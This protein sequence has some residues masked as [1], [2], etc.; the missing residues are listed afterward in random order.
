MLTC[1]I[2]FTETFMDFDN[3]SEGRPSEQRIPPWEMGWDCHAHRKG[4]SNSA[5]FFHVRQIPR[6]DAEDMW[7]DADGSDLSADWLDVS[8]DDPALNYNH[9]G[10]EYAYGDDDDDVSRMTRPTVVIVQV[11]Y[12]ERV[13]V[14]E[15]VD[16]QTGQKSEMPKADWDKV[17]K[18]TE[19]MPQHRVVSRNVWRQAF[20]GRDSILGESQPC[21]VASTFRPMTGHW[22][23]KD[24]RFYGLLRS[25]RDPQRFANKWL[26]NTLHILSVNSKGGVI[27]EK[28]AVDDMREFEES[29]AASDSVSV[30][31]RLDGIQPKPGPQMPAALMALTEFAISSIRDVS[32]V[33]MELMGMREAQQAGVLEYQRR[34]ASMTTLAFYFDSLR[35]YRKQQGDV[36][37]WFLQKWIAPTGR[38]VRIV[39]Q[40]QA[41]YVPLAMEDDTRKYDV[42]VDD[43]PQAPNEKEAAWQVIQVMLP[44][45]QNAGLGLEDWADIMDYSPLPSSF[46][47]KLRQK[48]LE[49][50][51]NPPQPDPAQIAQLENMQAQTKEREANA[52]YK[53]AQAQAVGQPDGQPE[54][55]NLFLLAAQVQ[56]DNSVAA[57]NQV[58]AS[59]EMQ[60]ADLDRARLMMDW[61]RSQ[62]EPRQ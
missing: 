8:K 30:V 48:A 22:D 17:A 47:E 40:D 5:L 4:L 42:I 24:K 21:E 2:G 53:M 43:S 36:I 27:V 11:Q 10:D 33:N 28:G 25:M 3:D 31:K 38:L 7:P 52:V 44:L 9:V 29:W 15:Y 57:L 62:Q 51:Q 54:R 41:Q 39:K 56:K 19:F 1:G 13:R 26:S 59:R 49:A 6:G 18:F 32:G 37:L 35:Y 50:S 61:L 16:P 58:K 45:L 12:R 34:Q 23:R 60:A 55:E 20:L 46:P 14:I